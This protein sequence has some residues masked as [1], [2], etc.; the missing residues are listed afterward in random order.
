MS[1]T[2]AVCLNRISLRN[3]YKIEG[4]GHTF[5]RECLERCLLDGQHCFSCCTA[6]AQHRCPTC[7]GPIQ[8]TELGHILLATAHELQPGDLV[9]V[10]G[11]QISLLC[12]SRVNEKSVLFPAMECFE[13]SELHLIMHGHHVHGHH[14]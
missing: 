12:V 6:V 7:R 2:C 14:P 3:N 13:C 10:D 8:G 11:T 4:C 5:H 9:E 1:D